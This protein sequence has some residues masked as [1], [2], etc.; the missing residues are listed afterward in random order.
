MYIIHKFDVKKEGIQV[1]K[2]LL[3]EEHINANIDILKAE[4]HRTRS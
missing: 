2:S 1:T 4:I 3:I